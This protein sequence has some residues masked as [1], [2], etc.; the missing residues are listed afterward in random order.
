MWLVSDNYGFLWYIHRYLMTRKRQQT[1]KQFVLSKT[2]TKQMVKRT[3]EEI[4][5]IPN[6][7][8]SMKLSFN[9]F[10]RKMGKN[11]DIIDSGQNLILG[12]NQS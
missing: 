7:G 10:N 8:N 12:R 1:N 6:R 3:N 9:L 11:R 2:R 4:M 5:S